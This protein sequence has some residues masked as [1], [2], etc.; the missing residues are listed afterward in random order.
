M[1]TPSLPLYAP[2]RPARY[3]AWRVERPLRL[4]TE[5]ELAVVIMSLITFALVALALT[6]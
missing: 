4:P 1:T 5:S 6:A 2:V 3:D